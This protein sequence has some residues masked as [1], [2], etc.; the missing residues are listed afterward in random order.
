MHN[1]Q[2]NV[3]AI[4]EVYIYPIAPTGNFGSC[5]SLFIITGIAFII[6]K[7]SALVGRSK[8]KDVSRSIQL[9]PLAILAL[10]I[11]IDHP[12]LHF[13]CHQRDQGLGWQAVANPV[14]SIHLDPQ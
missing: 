10:W 1:I 12:G 11:L 2:C 5:G 4:H 7:I 14:Y 6:T 8:I 9:P 13:H 3:L